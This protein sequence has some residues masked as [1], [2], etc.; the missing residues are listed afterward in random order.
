MSSTA[1][2]KWSAKPQQCPSHGPVNKPEQKVGKD[3]KKGFSLVKPPGHS[4]LGICEVGCGWRPSFQGPYPDYD[5][6]EL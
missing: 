5:N 6:A 2:L 1:A 3:P 4:V